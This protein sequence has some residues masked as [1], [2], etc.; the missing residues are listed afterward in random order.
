MS[1]LTQF[2]T[3]HWKW[4]VAWPP[5]HMHIHTCAD[6]AQREKWGEGYLEGVRCTLTEAV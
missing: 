2:D 4:V 6:N 3:T 1:T 5:V